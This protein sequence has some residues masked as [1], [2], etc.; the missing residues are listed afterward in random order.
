MIGAPVR[1]RAEAVTDA[2]AHHA[3]GPVWSVGWG[4]LRYV[5]LEAGSL[6]TLR[7][8]RVDRLE[9]GERVAAFVRPRRNGGYV[10]AVERGIALADAPDALPGAR[11][12]LWADRSV[13]MN[14]GTVDP[15]G[16]LL[17]G[18]MAYDARPAGSAVYRIDARLR[19][20]LVIPGVAVSNGVGFSPDGSRCYYVDSMERRVDVLDYHGGELGGRRPFVDIPEADGLPDGLTVSAD[21][22]VWVALWGGGAVLGY[23]S[24]GVLHTIVEVPVA[25]VSACAFGGDDLNT[26]F[27]TTSR[28]GLGAAAEAQAGSVFAVRTARR[29]LPVTAFA[30]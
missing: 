12:E 16:R 20:Q 15:D 24:D 8:D 4:G 26:L 17:A 19:P 27:I 14:D 6:L 2:V 1:L 5:D 9:L 3:E 22:S 7:G 18:G 23:G 30:G 11:I 21:G 13:R 25:Q 10:V 28:Q 29:G